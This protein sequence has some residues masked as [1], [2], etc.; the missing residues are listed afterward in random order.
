M[1]KNRNF[2]EKKIDKWRI[3][4]NTTKIRAKKSLK[5]DSAR[6]DLSG[7]RGP[8][9]TFCISL[10]ANVTIA[11]L[12]VKTTAYVLVS[13]PEGANKPESSKIVIPLIFLVK[14]AFRNQ[15]EITS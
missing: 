2:F 11:R 4:T 8:L 1:Q 13:A 9:R 6:P 10:G 14:T 15:S 3:T 5:K 12:V 7:G